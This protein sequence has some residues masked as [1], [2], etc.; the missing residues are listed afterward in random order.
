MT[1]FQPPKYATS[2]VP[3]PQRCTDDEFD[4][5]DDDVYNDDSGDYVHLLH[6]VQVFKNHLRVIHGSL[7][8]DH[9]WTQF[10]GGDLFAERL[11][12]YLLIRWVYM[13]LFVHTSRMSQD[14][15]WKLIGKHQSNNNDNDSEVYSHLQ[16]H[17]QRTWWRLDHSRCQRGQHE[18]PRHREQLTSPWPIQGMHRDAVVQRQPLPR[19]S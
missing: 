8:L 12:C 14:L 15:D 11:I 3:C 5:D 6:T 7:V 16:Q 19:Q 10:L 9:I 1:F 2:Y 17:Q 13:V 4:Y 18:A